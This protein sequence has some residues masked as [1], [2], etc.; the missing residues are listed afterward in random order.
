MKTVIRKATA[1]DL[2][3]IERIYE[4]IHTESENGNT[5]TGWIRGVYPTRGTAQGAL[6]RGE[7]FVQESEGKAVGTAIINQ[8]QVDVYK[9]APWEFDAPDGEVM[10]LHTLVIDPY[11][12]GH[13]FGS[14]FV[15]FYERYA[16][17]NDCRYLRID[18]NALNV[19]ARRF[20]Q[21]RGY[22]EIGTVP[23]EFNGIPDVDL[24]LIEKKLLEN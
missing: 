4:N 2:D 18:T 13:G 11:V 23:C 14:D 12:K 24:V 6:D 22:R 21:K 15:E 19:N 20:Y 16:A 8:T 7:L 5:Y 17:L 3:A 9:G 1:A 10:V